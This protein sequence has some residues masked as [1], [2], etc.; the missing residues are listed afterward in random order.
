MLTINKLVGT[1]SFQYCTLLNYYLRDLAAWERVLYDEA[2]VMAPD[3]NPVCVG[4]LAEVCRFLF[5]P[6]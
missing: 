3:N 1:K 6:F 5:P 2:V 4:C